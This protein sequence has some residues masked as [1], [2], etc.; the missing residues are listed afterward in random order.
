[1]TFRVT[2]SRPVPD[3]ALALLREAGLE[4]LGPGPSEGM[5]EADWTD[6]LARSEGLLCWL[7]DRVDAARLAQAPCLRVVANYAV[8]VDNIDR[9]AA[10][11]RG[12][13]VTN[14]PDVLTEATADLTLGL[15]L[16][17]ARRLVEADRFVR[18][19][20]FAGWRS[21]LLLGTE[22]AGKTLG[23]L[24]AGRIGSAV[25]RRAA[26]FGMKILYNANSPKSDLERTCGAQRVAFPPLLSRSDVLSIHCPL[27]SETRGLIARAELH[28]MKRT[29]ILVNTARGAVV[30]EADLVE[31][32]R[33]GTIAAAGLDVFESEPALSPGLCALPNAVLAPH[34]GSA[35]VETRDRMAVLAA[36]N[37]IA[38]S[39]G[40]EPANAVVRGAVSPPPR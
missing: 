30:R 8:G 38:V 5:A 11:V 18:E 19:G 31:A 32:L 10:G 27:S 29:S 40:E 36:R 22:L 37:V 21:D 28:R 25:A 13:W 2:V 35:T 23:L 33:D 15:I 24:G 6:R 26:A 12:I 3:A 4:V 14:T 20:R 7:S 9:E 34:I 17:C 16:A 39:R 1:M